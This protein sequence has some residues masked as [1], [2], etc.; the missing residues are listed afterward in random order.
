MK[1]VKSLDEFY[2][3]SILILININTK[4]L[5]F[6]INILKLIFQIFTKQIKKKLT[7]NSIEFKIN[8]KFLIQ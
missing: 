6:Q 7:L 4:K 3:R 2:D 8:N 1:Q 5:N